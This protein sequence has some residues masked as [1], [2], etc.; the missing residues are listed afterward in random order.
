MNYIQK[1][2]FDDFKY[3]PIDNYIIECVN[4][5]STSLFDGIICDYDQS[6][7]YNFCTD[8]HFYFFAF[9]NTGPLLV[10]Q[11]IDQFSEQL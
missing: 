3:N 9:L 2:T 5:Y 7:N 6:Y 8:L 4:P 1:T 11:I 10:A